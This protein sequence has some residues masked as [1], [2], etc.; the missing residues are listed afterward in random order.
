MKDKKVSIEERIKELSETYLSAEHTHC[1]EECTNG[2]YERENVKKF[3]NDILSLIKE[4]CEE[5]IGEDENNN[6]P[7]NLYEEQCD[8]ESRNELRQEQRKALS[9]LLGEDEKTS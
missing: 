8:E 7:D 9:V 3:T 6:Y 1:S 5:V 2:W 4:V